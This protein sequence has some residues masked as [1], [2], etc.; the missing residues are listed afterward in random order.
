MQLFCITFWI[1]TF[2]WVHAD[3]A[4]KGVLLLEDLDQNILNPSIRELKIACIRCKSKY[5][6]FGVHVDLNFLAAKCSCK[7]D[8]YDDK[9]A[10][11][12]A[13]IVF[14]QACIIKFPRE[15]SDF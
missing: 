12:Y 5:K 3:A 10:F 4:I 1:N 14:L 13:M 15:Y 8:R 6:I 9:S 2:K 11:P 7:Y